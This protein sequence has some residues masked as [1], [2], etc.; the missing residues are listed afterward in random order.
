MEETMEEIH[1]FGPQGRANTAL[2]FAFAK[3]SQKFDVVVTSVSRDSLSEVHETGTQNL[4]I[5]LW[6]SLRVASKMRR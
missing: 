3:I 4:S 2:A 5:T 1:E 6:P